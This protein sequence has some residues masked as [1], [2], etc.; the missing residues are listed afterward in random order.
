MDRDA[1]RYVGAMKTP[2]LRNVAA[3]PPYMHAG[4]LKTLG[5]VLQFYRKA[6][7][8]ELEHRDLSADELAKLESFLGAL[9]SPPAAP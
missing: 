3:R 1:G 8:P 7:R 9:S 2:S 4:Q 6:S 5:E